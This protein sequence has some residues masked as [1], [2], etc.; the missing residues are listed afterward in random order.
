MGAFPPNNKK[1]LKLLNRIKIEQLYL[2]VL[3]DCNISSIFKNKGSRSDFE[4][5]RGIFRVPILRTILDR[6]IYNDEY[7]NID[8][9]L[10]DSNVGARKHRNIRDNI[11]VLNAITNSVVNGQEDAIDVQVFDVEKCFDSLWVL[12]VFSICWEYICFI[13][14]MR[15]LWKSGRFLFFCISVFI[16]F[17]SS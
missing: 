11:F 15:S 4:F 13:Q 9:E 7:E 6:L 8:N 14:Y 10:S 5:Y 1:I 12:Y 16:L 2:E 17:I 3:E